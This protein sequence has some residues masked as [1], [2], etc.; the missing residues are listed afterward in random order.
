M[1]I[2]EQY[3]QYENKDIIALYDGVVKSL[4][5]DKEGAV[6]TPT[7]VVAQIIPESCHYR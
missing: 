1:G 3:N 2:A 7:Q 4:E 5:V 6:V